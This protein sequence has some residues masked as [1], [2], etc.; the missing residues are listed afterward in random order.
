MT[1]E[2][3][4]RRVVQTWREAR[5]AAACPSCVE[6]CC[7]GRLNPRLDRLEAFAHLPMVRRTIDPRPLGGPYVLDRRFWRWGSCYLVGRC[8][9]LDA[10]SRCAIHGQDARPRDCGEYPLHL[11]RVAGGWVLHAEQSC[12]IFRDERTVGEVRAFAREI[13]VELRLDATGG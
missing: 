12:P 7:G 1:D 4:L 10:S 11:E 9:H 5:C 13:G 2:T 8:P 3:D 6:V